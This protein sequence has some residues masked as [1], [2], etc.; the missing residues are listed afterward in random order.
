MNSL[1]YKETTYNRPF[2]LQR[3]DPHVYQHTDGIY[4]FTAS[5][6][7]Y[8]R[9]V[10][11]KAN[12]WK[13][14]SDAEEITIWTKHSQ[15][16]MSIHIWA[17]EI[18]YIRGKWY[19]YFAGGNINDIWAIRPYVLECAGNDPMK[20][21]WIE[22]GQMQGVDAF[23]F[24]DFSLDMT[25]FEHKDR[26]YCVWAEKV[27]V[28]KKISNLYL[29]EMDSPARLKSELILLSIPDYDWERVDFWVNEGPA[30]LSHDGRLYLTYSASATGACY[31]MGM[32]S[33]SEQDEI[34]NPRAWKK[35]RY[36]VLKTDV[37]M[38]MFGPGHNSFTKTE[39]GLEDI[40]FYHA[41]QYD[42][43]TGD[44]L[45]DP[46]RHTYCMRVE[47]DQNGKPVFDYKNII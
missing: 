44:P 11:R 38:G 39:D 17:P 1:N 8:D 31:C 12:C 13:N 3:A 33:I 43:I 26:L 32:L 9:I 30:I 21:E 46:N 2:I 40:M 45:Y 19:I 34:L 16:I 28:G 6:P 7:E 23:S 20:D 5:V 29:A 22:L 41:R 25:V 37:Q 18:H 42:E 14:L 4:Y 27:S 36:P 35:E 24:Q 15:G 10:L 47:W